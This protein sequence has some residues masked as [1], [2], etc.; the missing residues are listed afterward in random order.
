MTLEF[1]PLGRTGI[2]VSSLCLGTMT[3]GQQNTE[4]E[5]HAQLDRALDFGINFIDTAE[6]YSIPPKAE[7]QGSTETIIGTWLKAR[8]GRD[9]IVLASKASGPSTRTDLRSNA[10]RPRLDAQNLN[11]AIDASLKRLQTD[12]VDLYQLHWPNRSVPLFGD[13]PHSQA[14]GAGPG[15]VPIEETLDALDA[16]V[17]AGKVRAIGLSNETAWGVSR[18]LHLSETRD[19]PRVASVQNAYNLLNRTY[20]HGLSE[21]DA[22]EDVGLLAYSPLAQG[23]LTGKYLDGAKPE[24]ARTTLFARGGRYTKPG[25]EDA[26]KAYLKIAADFGIDPSQLAIA[27]VT[28]RSFVTSN[29][30][31]ATKPEQLETDLA[32]V[33]VKIT[34]EIEKAID[35][36]YQLHGSPAP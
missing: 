30:I 9:K 32:S 15:E 10:E 7:T 28:S 20:E 14:R 4:A 18:F 16:L 13:S 21:F 22:R 6:I 12:Y 36:V 33:D 19:L 8:G 27:W 31:G 11:E 1:R 29:I 23:Y 3:W 25:T 17:K 24:G 2:T 35:A 34:P 5:G 26:I